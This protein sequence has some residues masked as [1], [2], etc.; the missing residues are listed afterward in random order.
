M[1]SLEIV[2]RTCDRANVHVDWRTRY[3]GIDKPTLVKGCVQSL[4][5]SI[6][7]ARDI[8]VKLTILD[9]HSSEDTL[10]ALKDM[11]GQ[12]DGATVISLDQYGYNY[13]SHQQ[14]LLCRD[15]KLDL[16]YSVEDDYLHSPTAIQEMVD[17]FYLFSDRLKREDV[18]IYPFDEPSEYNPPNRTD[19]IV[20]GSARHWRTG[21]FT[22][23]VILSKPKLLQ[24][25]WP[26]FETMALKYNGDYLNPR[27]EHYEESNTIWQIWANNHAIR[28]NPLPSLAL[29]MQFEQQK[30][31][32]I[33][34]QKWW[35]EYTK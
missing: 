24:D 14:W 29:H 30:D 20:H 25:H 4:I 11:A 18:V 33:D 28:F 6:K 10:T 16:F 5:N 26:L 12:L 1:T 2:L 21:I 34:W 9:D 7:Q 32:F 23:N 13:S 35:Y 31:P 17:S 15:S 27:V 19:F 22:T 8:A 3:H